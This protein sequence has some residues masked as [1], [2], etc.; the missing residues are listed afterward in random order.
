MQHECLACAID[1]CMATTKALLRALRA[2]SNASILDAP[3]PAAEPT[4]TI[5][6]R[7]AHWAG[8]APSWLAALLLA[9][10]VVVVLRFPQG[11]LRKRH[12]AIEVAQ[13]AGPLLHFAHGDGETKRLVMWLVRH[14][15]TDQVVVYD[16]PG[17]GLMES[18][19]AVLAPRL[20]AHASAVRP[21]GTAL[22]RRV[23]AG[24]P[25]G[26]PADGRI[27]VVEPIDGRQL[28]WTLR[29]VR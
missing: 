29:S 26:E 17:R 7:L 5:A 8:V 25:D 18:L 9:H 19:A 24:H 1:R 16:G 3:M 15:P 13:A 22:G 20:V 6:A 12:H 23:F 27:G 10:V 28:R 2:S 11:S 4:P 21:D 14:A